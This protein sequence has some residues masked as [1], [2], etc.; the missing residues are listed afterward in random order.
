MFSDYREE[1]KRVNSS[2]PVLTVAAEHW[3][4][5][6]QAYIEHVAPGSQMEVLGGHMMFWEH[7]EKFNDL[8]ESFL[9][10]NS[11]KI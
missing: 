7:S 4:E 5:T 1:A 6:A 2:I 3:S 9:K 10:A 8:L 11:W